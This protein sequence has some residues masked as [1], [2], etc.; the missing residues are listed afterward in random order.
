MDGLQLRTVIGRVAALFCSRGIEKSVHG[1]E[2]RVSPGRQRK[3]GIETR[4]CRVGNREPHGRM[5][6]AKSGDDAEK[7]EHFYQGS[8]HGLNE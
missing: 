5:N 2:V 8:A 1:D 4:W 6:M 3:W 7:W